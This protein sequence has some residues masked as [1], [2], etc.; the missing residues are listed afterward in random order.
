MFAL[1]Q[2]TGF[3]EKKK[4]DIFPTGS[5]V[6]TMSADCTNLEYRIST[7]NINFGSLVSG[8][9]FFNIFP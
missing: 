3:R 5:Y 8:E 4:L 1:N 9:N 6:K 7:K 2:L